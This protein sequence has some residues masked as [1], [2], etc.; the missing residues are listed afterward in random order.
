MSEAQQGKKIAFQD[1]K[2]QVIDSRLCI[3]CGGCVAVCPVKCIAIKANGPELV[4]ECNACGLCVPACPGKGAPIRE[5]DQM[6]FNRQRTEEEDMSGFGI[7]IADRNLVAG[8]AEI[9]QKGYT[10]GKLTA[11]LAYLL[12][13]KE[14]DAAIVSRWGAHSPYPWFS[15]PFIATSREELLACTGSKYVF[16]PNLMA[17]AEVKARKEINSVAVVGLGCQVQGLRKMMLL[18]KPYQALTRKVKYV[19]GLYCGAP[20][21]QPEDVLA[22]IARFC[23]VAPEDIAA[24]DFRRVSEM[25]DVAFDLTLRDGSTV[26][27]SKNILR[28]FGA[29]SRHKRWHRCNLCTDYSAEFADISFGGVHVTTR[30]KAGEDLVTRAMGEGRLT[31]NKEDDGFSGLAAQVD[32]TLTVMKKETSRKLIAEL[33]AEG[34]PTPDYD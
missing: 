4:G 13:T 33:R 3:V 24:I 29:L 17:L 9:R 30:T 22:Y 34:K 14:I 12:E 31:N 11:I 32:K 28:L 5:L 2:E 18:G 16:T 8:D 26:S 27:E 23:K 25:F 7:H 21:V 15:W 1:L 19:F 6:V 10:G 20:M